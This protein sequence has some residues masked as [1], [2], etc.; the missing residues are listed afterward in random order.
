MSL[1]ASLIVKNEL[2]RYLQSNIGHLRE[3]CDLIC[4]MDDGSTDRTGEWLDDNA[5]EQMIV[6]HIDPDDGFFAGHEGRRRN[7]LL[8]WTLEQHP[9]WV[10]AIDADEFVT[11]GAA[12]RDFTQQ[13]RQVGTL[14]MKEVWKAQNGTYS[15][16][17]DGGWRPHSVPI[18]WR[19]AGHPRMRRWHIAD[20]ALACGREPEI[21]RSMMG[22]A[23]PTGSSILH[24]GWANEAGRDDRFQ[25]YVTADGGKFHQGS[26][27]A[28]IMWPDDKVVLSAERWPIGLLPYRDEILRAAS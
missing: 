26:H 7:A 27:L 22:R 5:D 12:V 11:D 15:I 9:T 3:F 13:P 1:V 19:A 14:D 10:L 8:E 28:S 21:I 23:R 25:R 6:K 20:R 18:M 24:F 17:M 4:V 2:G 16:R